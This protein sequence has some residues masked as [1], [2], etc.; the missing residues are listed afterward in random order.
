M[1]NLLLSPQ[2]VSEVLK[3]SSFLGQLPFLFPCCYVLQI[4]HGNVGKDNPDILACNISV[5]IKVIDVENKTHLL[6]ECR[7]VD[8]E[9]DVDK[10][11]QIN[12]PVAV[13]VEDGK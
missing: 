5:F 1:R 8:L 9:H 3:S 7:I 6:I 4:K 2:P 13:R 12:V 11:S 10:L